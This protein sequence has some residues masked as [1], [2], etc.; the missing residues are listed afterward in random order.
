MSG[1]LDT[2]ADAPH[3]R[4]QNYWSC[5]GRLDDVELSN[6]ALPFCPPCR[7]E[8]GK[9][10]N[11]TKSRTTKPTETSRLCAIHIK[12]CSL[13]VCFVVVRCCCC[14]C[15]FSLFFLFLFDRARHVDCV[16]FESIFQTSKGKEE[17]GGGRWTKT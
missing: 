12:I 11:K 14:C 4:V 17:E 16:D 3:R 15:C 13:T 8:N 5:G 1:S 9:K 10:Q 2:R 6:W 7:V